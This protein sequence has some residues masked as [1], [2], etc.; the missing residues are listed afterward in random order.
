[1]PKKE[2]VGEIPQNMTNMVREAREAKV[3]RTNIDQQI[4]ITGSSFGSFQKVGTWQC[5][6]GP[7]I[8]SHGTFFLPRNWNCYR[9]YCNIGSFS[10]WAYSNSYRTL[11]FFFF[12]FLPQEYCKKVHL[13]SYESRVNNTCSCACCA[14]FSSVH[15]CSSI[16]IYIIKKNIN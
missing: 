12:P 8:P 6:W 15:I 4:R 5:K 10:S 13:A 11:R 16:D 14:R 7:K 2:H 3:R 1:M 9:D